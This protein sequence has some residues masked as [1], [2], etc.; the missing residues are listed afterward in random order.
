MSCQ[1][2]QGKVE[3][4]SETKY[5]MDVN[6]GG[7]QCVVTLHSSTW[8]V[9]GTKTAWF[10]RKL[11]KQTIKCDNL[12]CMRKTNDYFLRMAATWSLSCLNIRN[13]FCAE[14]E[15]I[16]LTRQI[17]QS[18]CAD[19]IQDSRVW[20]E[21]TTHSCNINTVTQC[22]CYIAWFV[23]GKTTSTLKVINKRD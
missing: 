11:L 9:K 4:S 16:I 19:C 21:K 23:W 3:L 17:W 15:Q 20:T 1:E 8:P 10:R 18:A 13:M 2:E 6:R 14:S 12:T 7:E 22:G 5:N